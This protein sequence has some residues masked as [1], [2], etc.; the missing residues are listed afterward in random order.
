MLSNLQTTLCHVKS[1]MS[2]AD[3][4]RS[5]LTLCDEVCYTLRCSSDLQPGEH[6]CLQLQFVRDSL[7]EACRFIE[8]TD[9]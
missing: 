4:R 8:E 2:L 1:C 5:L 9:Y 6:D 3:I 7:N